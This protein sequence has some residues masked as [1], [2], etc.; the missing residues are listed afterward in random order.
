MGQGV[1]QGCFAQKT[2]EKYE[3]LHGRILSTYYLTKSVDVLE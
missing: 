2:D 3:P 1:R